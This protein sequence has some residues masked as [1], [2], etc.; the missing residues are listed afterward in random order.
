MPVFNIEWLCKIRMP[1]LLLTNFTPDRIMYAAH[2]FF[3]LADYPYAG[4]FAGSEYV[5]NAINSLKK[6]IDDRVEELTAAIPIQ[7]GIPLP[8]TLIIHTGRTIPGKEC[9]IVHGDTLK[10]ELKVYWR[11][12]L[13]EGATVIMA[14]S[15]FLGRRILIGRGI[16][17]ESGS[18]IKEPA[19][20][21]DQTEIRGGLICEDIA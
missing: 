4:V 5:W 2:D 14:G 15:V 18:L 12:D 1:D 19:I 3:D 21:G 10:G 6:F 8:D 11:G 17:V 7:S 9:R 16:M 13:L 20:I